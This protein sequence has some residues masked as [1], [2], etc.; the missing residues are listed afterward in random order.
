MG[1]I[2]GPKVH[3]GERFQVGRIYT[4]KRQA[5]DEMKRLQ[6][7]GYKTRLFHSLKT[8][9]WVIYYRR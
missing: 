4:Q 3:N 1:T 2:I 9:T 8:Y 5:E 7:D 6:K